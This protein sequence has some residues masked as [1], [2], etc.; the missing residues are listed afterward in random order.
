MRKIQI[1]SVSMSALLVFGCASIRN[2]LDKG[3]DYGNDK[4]ILTRKTDERPDSKRSQINAYM[5]RAALQAVQAYPLTTSDPAKGVIITDWYTS[6]Q[7]RNDRQKIRIDIMGDDVRR[8]MVRVSIQ[9]Q[10]R[11]G[12]EAAW[13]IAPVQATMAQNLENDILFTARDIRGW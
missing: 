5:W 2:D 4:E 12:D 1:V 8:D 13:K 10:V 3:M 11:D 7:N 6:P 9:R